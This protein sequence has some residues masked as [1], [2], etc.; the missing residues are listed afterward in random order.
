MKTVLVVDDDPSVLTIA[1]KWLQAEGV[2]LLTA[3]NGADGL[4]M[5]REHRLDVVVLDL[6]MPRMHGYTLIQEIRNDPD[7]GHVR[8]LV[9]SA[10]TYSSDIE[11]TRRLGADGYLSKPYDCRSSG[12]PSLNYWGK[13][14]VP[15]CAAA[16]SC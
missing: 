14:P 2:R 3:D 15:R 10:K 8:I 16:N 7:R 11:R 6:M 5:V 13:A 4:R 1:S 9:T 12:L